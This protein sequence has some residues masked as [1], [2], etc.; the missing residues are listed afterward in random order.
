MMAIR[1]VQM[2]DVQEFDGLV[3]ETYKRPYSFQQQDGCKGRG[4]QNFTVPTEEAYDF[5]DDNIL[6]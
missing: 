3:R 6:R 4:I 1:T 2:I 5:E